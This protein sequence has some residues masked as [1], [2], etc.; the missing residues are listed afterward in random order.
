MI[1]GNSR[2][3]LDEEDQLKEPQELQPEA[4]SQCYLILALALNMANP[5]PMQIAW[6]DFGFCTCRGEGDGN[7]PGTLYSRLLEDVPVPS[8]HHG[9]AE[10]ELQT[11][12]FPEFWR[13]YESGAM[14]QLMDYGFM[15]C[16]NFEELCTLET[17]KTL[18]ISGKLSEF[19]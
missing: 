9:L 6:F 5:N 19:A 15:N 1:F 16:Q 11:A 3:S 13:A 18:C 12:T 4:K 8:M 7:A 2:S 14:I 10:H 17:Y